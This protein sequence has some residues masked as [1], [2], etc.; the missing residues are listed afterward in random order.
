MPN[1]RLA[2]LCGL[3]YM[4]ASPLSAAPVCTLVVQADGGKC[5]S[6]WARNARNSLLADLP[7][8]LPLR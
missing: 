2:A 3:F 6:G 4:L 5:C 1:S 7:Q 8:L